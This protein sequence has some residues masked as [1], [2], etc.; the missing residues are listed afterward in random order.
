MTPAG[1]EPAIPATALPLGLT[2]GRF[3]PRERSGTL[4]QSQGLSEWVYE[5]SPSK[6]LEHRTF[7]HVASLIKRINEQFVYDL[8]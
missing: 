5:I 6:D 1:F 4:S 2:P 8:I 7:Q 3:T